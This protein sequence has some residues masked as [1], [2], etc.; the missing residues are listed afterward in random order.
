MIIEN[1]EKQFV[2]LVN[3]INYKNC[4]H[5]MQDQGFTRYLTSNGEIINQVIEL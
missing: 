1:Q 3:T 5:L 4:A 2:F